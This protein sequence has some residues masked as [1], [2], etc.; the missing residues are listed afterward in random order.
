MLGVSFERIAACTVSGT[1]GTLKPAS[2]HASTA[3]T[4]CPPLP[5]TMP[6]LLPIEVG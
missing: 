5:V 1:R 3:T 2:A 6:M 4:P